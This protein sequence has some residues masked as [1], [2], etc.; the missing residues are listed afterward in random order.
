MSA[1][2]GLYG[3]AHPEQVRAH[4]EAMLR[5]LKHRGAEARSFYIDRKVG[6]SEARSATSDARRGSSFIVNGRGDLALVGD[7]ALF[8]QR[9]LRALLEEQ[10]RDSSSVADSELIL[11]LYEQHGDGFVEHLDGQFAIALFDIRKK[12]LVL[13]RDRVGA[14]PLFYAES[15]GILFFASEIKAL[16]AVSERAPALCPEGLAQAFTYWAPLEPSTAFRNVHCL[17]AGHLLVVENQGPLSPKRYWDFGFQTAERLRQNPPSFSE[18]TARL[19][20]LLIDAVRSQLDAE[21]EVGAYLSGGLDSAGVVG[22]MSKLSRKPVRT[23]SIVFD[24]E[25]FDERSHQEQLSA[26]FGTVH[27]SLRCSRRDIAEAFPKL[28]F[29]T[30]TVLLRTAAAP[31][32]L[33]SAHVRDSGYGGVLS[34]EGADE[35]FAGYDL[36]K[37]AIIRGFWA[38]QPSSERRPKLLERLYPYLEHSPVK[39]AAMAKAFFG[40][41]FEHRSRAIFAHIPRWTTSGR[42]LAFFSK[43]LLAEIRDWDPL[44]HCEERLP[45]DID[46]WQPLARYQYVEA[47]TLLTSHLLCS[48]GDRV[49]MAHGVGLRMPY[50]NR[51]VI[52]FASELPAH[53][54]L[55]GLREK[56]ILRRAL[57]EYLPASFTHRGKQPYRA[58][59]SQ[60]FFENG[61]AVDYVDELLGEKRIREAGYFD[62]IAVSKL[63]EKC[64]RG[65]PL[66]F[67]D[68]QAFVGILSTMLLDDIFIKR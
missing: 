5:S 24:E 10:G 25:A 56:H 13:C 38:R 40:R 60:S 27:S 49:S 37:E 44:S 8:N 64:R 3:S 42:A 47:K 57:S 63:R 9:E 34:G 51:R 14:R 7:I 36:F 31:L 21:V 65:E 61:K 18:S 28:V 17:P 32:L 41:G 16:L 43:D 67:S 59:D 66:G 52:E 4:L 15:G 23:F 30:E 2:A 50:L 29:H 22:L 1:I 68:N 48:Q 35:V 6:L 26:H 39:T 45:V 53:F 54:K 62:P 20:A 11:R 19:R 58:P 12:R 33:L 46:E 55:R